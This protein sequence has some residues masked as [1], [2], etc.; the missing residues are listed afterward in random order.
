MK[1]IICGLEHIGL[2]LTEALLDL[3]EEV[4][5]ITLN[6]NEASLFFVRD[7]IA[8]Y[9]EGDARN[10]QT[11]SM[12]GIEQADY[13]LIFTS[14]ELKNIEINCKAKEVNPKIKTA[15][16]IN[17]LAYSKIV[18]QGFDANY[19]FHLPTIVSLPIVSSCI[20]K[21]ILHTLSTKNETYYFGYIDCSEHPTVKG[22]T[23]KEIETSNEVKINCY[24][25][26]EKNYYSFNNNSVIN[27]GSLVYTTTHE[28]HFDTDNSSFTSN[29]IVE[30]LLSETYKH[31]QLLKLFT[32]PP[33]IRKVI[34]LYSLLI[35]LSV[36]IFKFSL[37]LSFINSL[38]F[39]ITTTSTV[40]FGD[41]NL[42]QSPLWIKLYGCFVMLAGA[43]LLATLFSVITDNI[44]SK[45]LGG[46]INY[47]NRKIKN[48]I[49]IAG[50]GSIGLGVVDYLTKM[51]IKTVAIEKNPDNPRI[52]DLRSKL[53]VLIGDASDSRILLKAG[54]K[55]ARTL[56]ALIDDDLNNVN[57]VIKSNSLNNNLHTVARI[58][59]HELNKK[60]KSAFQIDNVISASSIA[61]PHILCSLIHKAI[62][63][64]GYLHNEIHII[65]QIDLKERKQFVGLNRTQLID[66][67]SINP[68]L[69]RQNGSLLQLSE[70]I[71]FSADD[72]LYIFSDYKSLVGIFAQ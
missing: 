6:K 58:F 63:W 8:C 55:K 45:R 5:V 28:K 10:G 31:F 23:V 29:P 32:I 53:P 2:R 12:A 21:N 35:V 70:D 46:Y 42:Q 56:A 59:S 15:L 3:N 33:G 39:V 37:G 18:K 19:V 27:E 67:F 72:Q 11:L 26:N 38:Y 25:A 51:G 41:F 50:I 17:N 14:N 61:V 7:R 64:A 57:I 34:F 40:G 9:I 20:N 24:L 47:N 30:S 60:A 69:I 16:L 62:L 22:K 52:K 1:Y 54:I 4:T 36:F 68:L 49:I 13:F 43:A 66:Q 65:Y 48:H 44:I 71:I